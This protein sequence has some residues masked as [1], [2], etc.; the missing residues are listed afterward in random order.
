[1]IIDE[2]LPAYPHNYAQHRLNTESTV[3]TKVTNKG[4]VLI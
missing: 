4:R 3:Q 2:V 1:M